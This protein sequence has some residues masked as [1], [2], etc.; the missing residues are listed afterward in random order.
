MVWDLSRFGC[1]KHL[2]NYFFCSSNSGGSSAKEMWMVEEECYHYFNLYLFCMGNQY[3]MSYFVGLTTSKRQRMRRMA[4]RSCSSFTGAIRVKYQISHGTRA[5]TG[6]SP[7]S[8]KTTY[9]RSGRWQRIFTMM[10]RTFQGKSPPKP[11]DLM[12]KQNQSV[13]VNYHMIWSNAGN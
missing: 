8:R 9:C 3:I 13:F 5:R 7:V 12:Y 1:L 2:N 6:L 4:P 10:R 11:P